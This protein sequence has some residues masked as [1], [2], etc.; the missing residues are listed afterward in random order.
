MKNLLT[1]GRRELFQKLASSISAIGLAALI[2]ESAVA[3]AENSATGAG[4]ATVRVI[5]ADGTSVQ[6]LAVTDGGLTVG[7]KTTISPVGP[8]LNNSIVKAAI[9]AIIAAGGPQLSSKQITLLG[10]KV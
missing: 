10:G 4:S 7:G 3:L 1:I 6:W 8:G 9:A 5:I 2:P